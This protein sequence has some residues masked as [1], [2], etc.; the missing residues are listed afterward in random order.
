MTRWIA[1]AAAVWAVALVAAAGQGRRPAY[2]GTLDQHPAIDYRGTA[3]ADVMTTLQRDLAGGATPLVFDGRQ[4]YLRALLARLDVPVESQVLLFSKTGIQHPF[5]DP[6]HP[7]ALYFNDQVIVG[8]IPGA[9]FI[10]TASHDATQGVIFQTI[11]QDAA[12]APQIARPDRCLTCHLSA[13]SL[14]VPGILVRSM[15]TDA[16]GRTRPQLGSSLVDHRTPLDQRWG[17]WYVTGAHGAAR[18]LGNAMVTDN[19]APEAAVGEATLNRMTLDPRVDAGA[20]PS[21]TSDIVALLVFDHQGRAMNLLTRLGW[22]ARVAAAES[23]LDFSIGELRDLVHETADYLLFADEAVLPA[24][25]QGVTGF[26]RAFSERG[27][28]DR[29]GR[30]LRQLDLQ[31][32]LFRY[33]CSYMIYS[34]AFDALPGPA[35]AAVYARMQA[36]LGARGDREVMEILDDTRKG[37]R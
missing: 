30:S 25:V 10:E 13:N 34:P 37:W 28:R 31:T 2:P 33:R 22:E 19:L 18:H 7:R 24:P 29:R 8:Y 4:G 12:G 26:A 36:V 23:G 21:A 20:Y 32:R 6:E 27:P 35:R 16:T 14:D 11:A 1:C 17:G 3:T 5:T 9:P 15:F